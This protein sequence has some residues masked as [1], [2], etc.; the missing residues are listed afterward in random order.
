MEFWHAVNR[1]TD[2]RVIFYDTQ[3]YARFVHNLFKMNDTAHIENHGRSLAMI[4][5]RG[6]SFDERGP[7]RLVDIHAWCLMRNHFHLLLSEKV[8]RG[9]SKF[10]MKVNVGYA[11]YFNEKYKRSGTLFQART[12]KV[13]IERDGHYLHI[14]NYIHLNPLDY[15]KGAGMWRERSVTNAKTAM[16]HLDKYRWSS[17]LDYCGTKNFP[18]LLT[19]KEFADPKYRVSLLQYL[20]M[21]EPATTATIALE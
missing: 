19:T 9:I 11:K 10:L 20:K 4:D 7:G 14:L 12:K 8:D 15:L 18:S 21:L 3:D 13:L 5:L 2:K 16:D 1:G 6:R 17:Y